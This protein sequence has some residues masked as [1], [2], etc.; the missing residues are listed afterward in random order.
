MRR[1]WLSIIDSDIA[2]WFDLMLMLMLMSML[3]LIYIDDVSWFECV[4][5]I[6]LFYSQLVFF[7]YSSYFEWMGEDSRQ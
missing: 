3:M 5:L 1:Y 7:Y 4:T 2:F 6:C